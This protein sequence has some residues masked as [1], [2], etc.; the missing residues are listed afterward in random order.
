MTRTEFIDDDG[1]Q[2][3]SILTRLRRLEQRQ[4]QT[5]RGQV[6]LTWPASSVTS[7]VMTVPHGLV[8]TPQAVASSNETEL[9]IAVVVVDDTNLT[10]QAQDVTGGLHGPGSFGVARWVAVL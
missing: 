5:A 1:T 3:N 4:P 6:T 7:N 10:I 9:N 8:G 2:Y